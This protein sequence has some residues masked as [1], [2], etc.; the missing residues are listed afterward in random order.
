[1]RMW[2]GS[3]SEMDDWGREAGGWDLSSDW[4]A[5]CLIAPRGETARLGSMTSVLG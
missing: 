3:G 1:M 4:E 2:R 5:R